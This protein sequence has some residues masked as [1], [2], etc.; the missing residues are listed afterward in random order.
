MLP[1]FS[2]SFLKDN[3]EIM[4]H[5]YY[6]AYFKATSPETREEFWAEQA[7]MVDWY[8]F[9]TKILDDSNPPFYRWFKDGQLNTCYN[10]IDRHLPTQGDKIGLIY[11]S[12]VTKTS[13]T[14]TWKEMYENISKFAG[15]L[16]N[17]GVQKGD[18]IIIYMPM[19]PEAIFAQLACARIGAIHSVVFG[20]FAAKELA[21]RIVDAEPK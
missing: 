18:R 2:L 5:P 7:K 16:K 12:A 20:G 4:N 6:N 8:K 14:F 10:C 17:H 13:K 11:D 19:I 15:V 3:P 9:P 1:K 21:S